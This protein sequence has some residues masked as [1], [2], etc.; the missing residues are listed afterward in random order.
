MSIKHLFYAIAAS[1]ILLG[2]ASCS[3]NEPG[4]GADPVDFTLKLNR[5]DDRGCDEIR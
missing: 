1:G 2:A 3:D 5:R 4:T